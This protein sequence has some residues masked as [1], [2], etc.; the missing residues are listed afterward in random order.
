M[1]RIGMYFAV[2]LIAGSGLAAC[3]RNPDPKSA[4]ESA[5]SPRG[6]DESVALTAAEGR[7]VNGGTDRAR[8]TSLVSEGGTTTR[9]VG[10]LIYELR[11]LDGAELLVRGV[12]QDE[13]AERGCG[14]VLSVRE[15]EVLAIDGQRPHVG[16]VIRQGDA[17][18][19]AASDTLRLVPQLDELGV[20]VETKIWVVGESDSAAR[21]LHIQSYGVIA[22]PW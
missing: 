6:D 14:R 2:A 3:A 10:P 12:M 7:V 16:K 4:A 22:Q 19:L 13:S 20:L 8:I 5:S 15:Y 18:W 21:E 9:L 11:S 1:K 17:L